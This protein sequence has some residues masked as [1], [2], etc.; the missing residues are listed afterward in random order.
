MIEQ[1]IRIQ[2]LENVRLKSQCFVKVKDKN[3]DKNKSKL[4]L[5]EVC[6]AIGVNL[7]DSDIKSLVIQPK[8][9]G[10]GMLVLKVELK[11]SDNKFD[12]MRN[13]SKCRSLP[14]YS[15]VSFF[16]V[17]S[18]DAAVLYKEAKGLKAKGYKFV[19]HRNGKIFV[20]AKEDSQP[21]LISSRKM[22]IE[23]PFLGGHGNYGTHRAVAC[24]Y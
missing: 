4:Y 24:N 1:N 14:R 19:F 21:I 23:M 7:N 22:I 6:N 15:H 5:L 18:H 3:I 20:K 17:L 16:D 2:T 13:K 11:E 12:I 8:L 9:S 10:R